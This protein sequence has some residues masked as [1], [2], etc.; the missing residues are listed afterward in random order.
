VAVISYDFEDDTIGNVPDGWSIIRV[1]VSGSAVVTESGGDQFWA[2]NPPP[3]GLVT[4]LNTDVGVGLGD[5]VVTAKASR[6]ATGANVYGYLRHSGGLDTS[7]DAYVFTMDNANWKLT[8]VDNGSSTLLAS[9]ALSFTPGTEFNMKLEASGGIIRGRAWTGS[10]PATW[11]IEESDSTY[12]T[13][14]VAFGSY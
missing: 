2:F 13:G 7:F 11:D 12:S 3:T 14:G 10:E 4:A 6:Q 9:V 8:R 1:T 5:V